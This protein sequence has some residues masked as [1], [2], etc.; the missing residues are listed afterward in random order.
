M[1]KAVCRIVAA[2]GLD[3]QVSLDHVMCCGVGACFACVV[4]LKADTP[5]GWEYVRTCK[6]GPVFP[7]SLVRW[8][9]E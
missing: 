6:S 2:H 5:D 4:R 7:A 3:A 8:D 1:L 9:P